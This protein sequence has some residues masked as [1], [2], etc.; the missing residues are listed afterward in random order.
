VNTLRLVNDS[1]YYELICI[2]ECKS[3]LLV[4]E[5]F[6]TVKVKSQ[7]D[8]L[9]AYILDETDQPI[10]LDFGRLKDTKICFRFIF[11]PNGSSSNMVVESRGKFYYIPSYFGEIT[12]FG[13][14]GEA[15]EYWRQNRY[16]LR[17]VGDFY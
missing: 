3:C 14:L 13:S 6:K 15:F 5:N 9:K 12:K 2:D 7:F 17:G 8:N 11:Y 16:L 1:K 10:K 4:D